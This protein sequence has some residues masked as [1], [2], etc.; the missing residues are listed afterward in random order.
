MLYLTIQIG[1]FVYVA[2]VEFPWVGPAILIGMFL[3]A[4]LPSN[5]WTEFGTYLFLIG[6]V[7][8]AFFDIR[9]NPIFNALFEAIFL[10]EGEYLAAEVIIE[11]PSQAEIAISGNN[12]IVDADGNRLR[13]ISDMSPFL[14][15]LVLYSIIYGVLIT[16]RGFFPKM[17]TDSDSEG[18]GKRKRKQRKRNNGAQ[19]Q[20]T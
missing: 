12:F 10:S 1:I 5:G 18:K 3:I 4:L 8:S 6:V 20:S 16:L 14:Y 17:K 19:P 15:R 2:M 7:V 11:K 13:D 9:G